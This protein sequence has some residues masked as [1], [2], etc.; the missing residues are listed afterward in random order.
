MATGHC[1]RNVHLLGGHGHEG[2]RRDKAEEDGLSSCQS[3]WQLPSC[4]VQLTVF[5]AN[6]ILAETGLNKSGW[7]GKAMPSGKGPRTL[8]TPSSF[9]SMPGS[10]TG[11]VRGTQV[12]HD[13]I[14]LSEAGEQARGST[15]DCT[16]RSREETTLSSVT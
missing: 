8:H 10:R 15:G 9:S 7:P 16:P 6:E 12:L 5:S 11:V 2:E 1:P 4:S 3:A 14:P 13:R